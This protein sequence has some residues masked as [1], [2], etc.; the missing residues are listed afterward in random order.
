M[1]FTLETKSLTCSDLDSEENFV[2]TNIFLYLA[3]TIYNLKI[4]LK[5]Y[6]IL[7]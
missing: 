4:V 3:D 1:L 6:N 5:I 2:R 7:I